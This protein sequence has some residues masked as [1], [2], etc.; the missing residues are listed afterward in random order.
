MEDE[1]KCEYEVGDL[2]E[3]V[4]LRVPALESAFPNGPPASIVVRVQHVSHGPPLITVVNMF[5]QQTYRPDKLQEWQGTD[6]ELERQGEIAKWR[7][8]SAQEIYDMY[9]NAEKIR[10]EQGEDTEES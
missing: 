1:P 10:Q 8:Q 3:R 5:G 9:D 6:E 2:V 7:N 4:G